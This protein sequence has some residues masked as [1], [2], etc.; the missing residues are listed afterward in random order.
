METENER[1]LESGNAGQ[2][3]KWGENTRNLGN[4]KRYENGLLVQTEG[5][6]AVR[7]TYLS[8]FR[9]SD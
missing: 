9:I 2:K 1:K 3:T 6:D 7:I 5:S 8:S 4:V